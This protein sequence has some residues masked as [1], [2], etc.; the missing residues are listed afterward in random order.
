[1]RQA[2]R[3]FSTDTV[4]ASRNSIAH[5]LETKFIHFGQLVKSGFTQVRLIG[6]F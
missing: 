4:R 1:L 5:E 6:G 2:T 3:A